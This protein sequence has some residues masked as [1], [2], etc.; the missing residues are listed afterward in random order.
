MNDPNP[1]VLMFI[2]QYLDP[3]S[4]NYNFL[5]QNLNLQPSFFDYD[6]NL[7]SIDDVPCDTKNRPCYDLLSLVITLAVLVF[8]SII[9]SVIYCIVRRRRKSKGYQSIN[10]EGLM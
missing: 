6:W 4:P 7:N 3:T 9:I 8:I 1:T 5:K 10:Q 2:V